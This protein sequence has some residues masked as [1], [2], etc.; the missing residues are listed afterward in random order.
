MGLRVLRTRVPRGGPEP[1]QRGLCRSGRLADPAPRDAR[2]L[3]RASRRRCIVAPHPAKRPP[4]SGH[5]NGKID[6]RRPGRLWAEL[7]TT[8]GGR[9]DPEMAVDEILG[10]RLV[11]GP[12]IDSALEEALFPIS[13]PKGAG[14]D[15]NPSNIATSPTRTRRLYW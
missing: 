3:L 1:V 15:S 2:R 11:D 7:A 12:A 13:Q 14:R 8:V 4:T 5:H 6:P 9:D 10:L